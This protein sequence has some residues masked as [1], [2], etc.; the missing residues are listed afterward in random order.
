MKKFSSVLTVV[1]I[2]DGIDKNAKEYKT[3][4]VETPSVARL[5]TD[6]GER[7]VRV[8]NK[9]S[10]FNAWKV[11]NL[12]SMKG[13][14]DFGY[15][16]VVGDTIAGSIV[17]RE[18]KT[19]MRNVDKKIIGFSDTYKIEVDGRVTEASTYSCIV[20]GDTSDEASYSQAIYDAFWSANHPLA[21]DK[22]VTSLGQ[23]GM[24]VEPKVTV[25]A[26]E[27]VGALVTK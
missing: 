26:N 17:K 2:A 14:P 23:V 19:T 15:D 3:I 24:L 20:L 27:E 16:F 11:S 1:G 4:Q 22:R 6:L 18:V 21:D 5:D 7:I 25:T 9:T 12:Q 8:K 13:Q 10:A